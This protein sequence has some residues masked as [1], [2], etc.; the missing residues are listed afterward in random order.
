MHDVIRVAME[1]LLIFGETN[2]V[3]VLKIREIHKIYGPRNKRTLRYLV[4]Y[5]TNSMKTLNKGVIIYSNYLS[6]INY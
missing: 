1:F 2:F 6:Q 3:E 5:M 4:G